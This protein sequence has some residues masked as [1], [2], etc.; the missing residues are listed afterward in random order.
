MKV[1]L[2]SLIKGKRTV[3]GYSLIKIETVILFKIKDWLDM[4]ERKESG[5][6]VDSKD[7]KKY[8]NDILD[9]TLFINND[10]HL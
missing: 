9:Y 5:E 8:K 4:K 10:I 3:D 2:A 7:I 1:L 6:Y